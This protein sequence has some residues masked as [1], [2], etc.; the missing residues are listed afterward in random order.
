M[1]NKIVITLLAV[2][3]LFNLSAQKEETVFGNPEIKLS[4][5]WVSLD[6][7]YAY[8][9]DDFSYSYG[10]S[11]TAEISRTVLLGYISHDF[12]QEPLVGDDK[13]EFDL[14]YNGFLIGYTPKSFKA[15]HPRLE[16]AAGSGDARYGSE[17]DRVFVIQPSLG[18]EI[19]ATRWCRLGLQGGYRFITYDEIEG[20]SSSDLSSPFIQGSIRFG[21]SWGN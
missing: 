13:A 3:Y 11:I 12:R 2:C 18:V 9:N 6:P 15:F 20:V 4:G 7:S 19:N 8:F 14:D 10:Y 16:L 21:I 17:E 1:K 5:I